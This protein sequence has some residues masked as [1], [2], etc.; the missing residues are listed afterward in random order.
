MG[1][2]RGRLSPFALSKY[3]YYSSVSSLVASAISLPSL[4][5]IKPACV[6]PS[7]VSSAVAKSLAPL[8]L[9]ITL[10]KTK[11]ASKVVLASSIVTAPLATARIAPPCVAYV[12]LSQQ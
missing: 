12:G 11:G 4:I 10:A 7:G 8:L 9:V 1:K 5:A 6:D 3:S 2:R